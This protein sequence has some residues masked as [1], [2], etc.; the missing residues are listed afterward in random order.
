MKWH[1]E[2]YH[3]L[4]KRQKEI[5][6]NRTFLTLLSVSLGS[7]TLPLLLQIYGLIWDLGFWWTRKQ[8]T[9]WC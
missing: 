6:A 1:A 7:L 2:E 4:E 5:C 9:L 8:K 3:R